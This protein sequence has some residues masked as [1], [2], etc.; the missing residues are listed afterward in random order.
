MLMF[1]DIQMFSYFNSG[2]RATS[3]DFIWLCISM[4]Y[5]D[6]YV[7]NIFCLFLVL[8]II[9]VLNFTPVTLVYQLYRFKLLS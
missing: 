1:Y 7:A 2:V 5:L 6:M 3:T 8:N 9:P 4:I